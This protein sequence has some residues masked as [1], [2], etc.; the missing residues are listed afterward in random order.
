MK[1]WFVL[2]GFIIFV[3]YCQSF[4]KIEP[5]FD[6]IVFSENDFFVK[7]IDVSNA[8]LTTKN[9]TSFL[10]GLLVRQIEYEVPKIYQSRF[11]N[12]VFDIEQKSSTVGI[13]KVEQFVSNQFKSFG[14]QKEVE[15]IYFYGLKLKSVEVYGK[16]EQI[17]AFEEKLKNR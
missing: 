3:G 9:I 13:S 16:K 6:E 10:D 7:K 4:F 12:T 1:K 14:Y 15:R 11:K 8:S 17:E 2:I 5:V